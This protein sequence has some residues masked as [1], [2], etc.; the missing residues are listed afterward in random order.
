MVTATREVIVV[1]EV[2]VAVEEAA[3]EAEVV[4]EVAGSGVGRIAARGRIHDSAEVL[5]PPLGAVVGNPTDTEIEDVSV[6]VL[7]YF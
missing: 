6:I 2:E 7:R 4:A 3:A 5:P 1:G